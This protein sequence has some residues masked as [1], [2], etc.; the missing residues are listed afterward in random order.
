M[1]KAPSYFTAIALIAVLPNL[2]VA[3]SVA[4]SLSVSFG[5]NDGTVN[6]GAGGLPTDISGPTSLSFAT[7]SGAFA[8]ASSVANQNSTGAISGAS[9]N[10]DITPFA[11]VTH[12]AQNNDYETSV[13]FPTQNFNSIETQTTFDLCNDGFLSGSDGE[14]TLSQECGAVE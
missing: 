12:N 9:D 11:D 2:S 8:V 7:A 5:D 4:T 10:S 13:I 6:I 1:T 3:Q 14:S